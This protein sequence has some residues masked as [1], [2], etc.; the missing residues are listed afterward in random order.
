MLNRILAFLFRQDDLFPRYTPR[1]W[2]LFYALLFMALGVVTFVRDHWAVFGVFSF[3]IGAG[4]GVTIVL[5]MNWDK[6]IEYW[7]TISRNAQI[8]MSIK[9]PLVRNEIWRAYGFNNVPTNA[10]VTE[11]REDKQGEFIGL[12]NHT[13]PATPAVMQMIAD[14]VLMSGNLTFKEEDY[15]FV[16][17]FRKVKKDFLDRKIITQNHKTNPRFSHSFNHKGVTWLY[18]FASESVKLELSKR[19]QNGGGNATS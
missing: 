11:R 7:E 14:K 19:K 4:L 5:G 8:M 13:L 6:S 1:P 12:S 2:H 10:Q 9:D 15:K 3:A 16:P 17:K 18:E